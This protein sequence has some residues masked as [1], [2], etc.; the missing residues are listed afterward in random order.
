MLFVAGTILSIVWTHL[1]IYIDCKHDRSIEINGKRRRR[2]SSI[3]IIGPNVKFKPSAP[4]YFSSKKLKSQQ[5][6]SQILNKTNTNTNTNNSNNATISS[7]GT[8]TLTS[9][10]INISQKNNINRDA[11]KSTYNEKLLSKLSTSVN[12]NNNNKRTT[13][14]RQVF[15]SIQRTF[16]MNT[17]NTNYN[18]TGGKESMG[19]IKNNE[20]LNSYYY[21]PQKGSK[22][23][24]WQQSKSICDRIQVFSFYYPPK[25]YI[26]IVFRSIFLV[27][28]V[29][30]VFLLLQ[31]ILIAPVRYVSVTVC[32]S[33]YKYVQGVT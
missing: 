29:G 4:F 27:L 11:K 32:K 3:L 1:L 8:R 17:D 22:L 26:G 14:E 19:T 30:N 24:M 12:N 16:T 21:F 20:I 33:M 6:D 10:T 25:S 2:Y 7:T 18:G 28:I 15:S 9:D 5:T 31:V 23:Y 13:T